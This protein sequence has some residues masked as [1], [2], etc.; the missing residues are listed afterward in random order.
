M[1]RL[2]LKNVRRHAVQSAAVVVLVAT[3]ALLMYTLLMHLVGAYEGASLAQERGGAEIMLVPKDAASEVSDSALLF[4]G[5]PFHIY[6]SSDT[7][8]EVEGL[9][10]V[11]RASGQFFAQTLSMP[12][13]TPDTATRIVGVDLSTDWTLQPLVDLD[14][15]QGLSDDEVLLGSRVSGNPDGTV[16]ILGTKYRIAGRLLPTGSDLDMCIIADISMVRA[17]AESYEENDHLWE[18]FGGADGAVSAVLVD[19]R[20]DLDDNERARAIAHL[21][22]ISQA[23]VIV[24]SEA[25]DQ[26]GETIHLLLTI[27]LFATVLIVLVAACQL[28]SRFYSMAWDRR[29]EF[30]VYRMVGATRRHLVLLVVGEALLLCGVGVLMGLLGG[31][32]VFHASLAW[33]LSTTSFPFV[34]PGVAFA[35]VSAT[36]IVVL[37]LAVAC[38]AIIAPLRQVGKISPAL[39]MRQSDIV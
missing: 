38:L 6:M 5:A 12:C 22:N 30:A 15:S 4:T 24:R 7:V 37:W 3:G 13:C 2:V 32:A 35:V 14:L 11:E 39:V 28:F 1:M 8:A 20:D 19:L 23:K 9:F 31:F 27:M 29:A 36:A 10:G 26:A 18:E 16:T 25:V 34:E 33:L 17:F 21:K